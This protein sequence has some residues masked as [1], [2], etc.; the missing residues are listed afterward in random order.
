M[1]ATLHRTRMLGLGLKGCFFPYQ[2][3]LLSPHCLLSSSSANSASKSVSESPLSAASSSLDIP[4]TASFVL[5]PQKL[6]I[7]FTELHI[8]NLLKRGLHLLPCSGQ[9][10][11]HFFS[12]SSHLLTSS[13]LSAR[14]S[15]VVVPRAAARLQRVRGC[16]LRRRR[17]G[18]WRLLHPASANPAYPVPRDKHVLVRYLLAHLLSPF[19]P[20][21]PFLKFF[22]V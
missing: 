15:L 21:I 2:L 4:C 5:S 9:V 6:Y 10:T 16:T 18:L 19:A 14:S 22:Y 12:F 3:P 1:Y 11:L 13:P 17:E 7:H 20:C 8:P